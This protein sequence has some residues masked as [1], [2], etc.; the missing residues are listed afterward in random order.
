MTATSFVYFVTRLG[1]CGIAWGDRGVRL[2]QL[3]E[4]NAVRMRARM[5]RRF[6]DAVESAPPAP[7]QAAID[8]IVALL[9]GGAGDLSS[10]VLDMQQVPELD[11]RVYAVARTIPPGSTL[12][13]GEVAA[14]LGEPGA[15]R[16]V[17][18]AL[19]RNPFAIVVP[20]HR[21]VAANGKLGGFSAP[22]GAATKLRLLQIEGAS[23]SY[24]P[25]LFDGSVG[26]ATVRAPS[27]PELLSERGS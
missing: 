21:V 10:V 11:R 26:P 24:T 18:Q 16:D 3:P 4:S 22:G 25:S 6:P 27:R 15:A 19:G 14:R 20:C 23:I 1:R 9:D 7:V 13:Y 17:G 2:V 12:S 5:L 8:G